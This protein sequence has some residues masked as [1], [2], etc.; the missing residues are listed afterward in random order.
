MEQNIMNKYILLCL[1]FLLFTV[2]ISYANEGSR[3]TPN[4]LAVVTG[5]EGDR[6]AMDEIAQQYG[7]SVESKNENMYSLYSRGNRERE[8]LEQIAEEIKNQFQ[9]QKVVRE[10]GLLGYD[11]VRSNPVLIPMQV[12]VAFNKEMSAEEI[13]KLNQ[14]LDVKIERAPLKIMPNQYIVSI[15]AGR[16]GVMAL[17]EQYMKTGVVEYAH[18]NYW[19]VEIPFE[20]TPIDPFFGEQWHHRNTGQLGGLV[21]ADADT[22][23]A[24]DFGL[25][26]SSI[27]IAVFDDGSDINHEDLQA[28]LYVNPGEIAGNGVD[29]D[30]NGFIDDVNGWD[31]GSGD[32]NPSAQGTE[33]HGTAVSGVAIARANNSRGVAGACP[34][35]RWMPLRRTYGGFPD[36]A[37]IAAFDYVAM[38]D[39]DIM[40]NSWGH[41]SPFGSVSAGVAA[42]INNANAS[43]VTIFFAAGNGNSS[44]WCVSS[45]PSLNSVVAV[46]SS[47]NLDQ[48][49]TESAWGNCVDILTPSHRGYSAPFMGTKNITTTDRTGNAGYNLNNPPPMPCAQADPADRDYTHCFG[50]TSSASPFTAGIAGLILSADNALN[51]TQVE[52]LI[53]DTADKIVPD[54]ATYDTDTGFSTTHAYG[55]T[56]AYEAVRVVSSSGDG[57]SGVD[58]FVR[59]NRLDWGNTTGY[60]GQQKSNVKFDSPRSFIGHWR[61]EDIKVDAPPYQVP[62]TAATFDAFIDEKPSLAPGDVNRAYVRVRNR[63]Y[64]TAENISVKLMWTQF[65]TALP[66]LNADFWTQYPNDSALAANPWTSMTCNGTGLDYCE[67]DQIPYSGASV[68]G[69]AADAA[70]IARFDFDA[71]SY[72]P[73]LANHYCLLA[74]TNADNDPVD[75]LST[76]IFLADTLTPNDNNVT[77]RN[78]HNLDTSVAE[79]GS[80]R[81]FV[82]NPTRRVI[83][84][85]LELIVDP[86]LQELVGLQAEGFD[87][88]KP[89][90]MEAGAERLVTLHVYSQSKE[91]VGDIGVVQLIEGKKGAEVLGGLTIEL[92]NSDLQPEKE[93]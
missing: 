73:A 22:S 49:V 81:F 74:V 90:R 57:R 36:S 19:K 45:Y 86:R 68:A 6:G 46:S 52:N 39:V 9:R 2:H 31:F 53:Q 80:F 60:L 29:D 91:A 87:W 51:P 62:P 25:G 48:K 55:R 15:P 13:R 69:T 75:S 7:F 14:E 28:N 38:M 63:G 23:W 18:P 30:G 78:Y 41:G 4:A 72:D 84:T 79:G 67:I 59:D 24:W 54:T 88:Q 66:A 47:T 93:K 17:I 43:G 85:W 50:G 32:N 65:G 1:S 76:G 77:H 40:N 33:S 64:T 83:E 16:E 70:G 82:R 26:S 5:E 35:C 89:F 61:S 44:G 42:A 37:R 10:V 11:G 58:I 20:T 3:V 92:I 71:P 34:Q 8:E 21:D 27:V 12:I 56:N